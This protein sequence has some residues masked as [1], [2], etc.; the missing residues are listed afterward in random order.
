MQGLADRLAAARRAVGPLRLLAVSKGHP[1]ESLRA[2]YALGQREFGENYAQEMAAKAEALSD[3]DE[4]KLVFIGTVQSNKIA[5]IV[6]TASEIQSVGSERH[7]RLIAKAARDAGKTPFPIYLLVNAGDE[8]SKSGVS[9]AIASQVAQ[10]IKAEMP[11]LRLMGVMAI[12]P[13]LAGGTV[14]PPP[15]YLALR[16]LASEVG[17]GQLSLGM[18]DDLAVAIQAGTNCVRIGTAIFGPRPSR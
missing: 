5:T 13:P 3:L 12:P 6:R 11:E 4:L 15:L 18:S 17:E 9:L 7:A 8:D 10:V 14:S 2:A 1:A 16:V